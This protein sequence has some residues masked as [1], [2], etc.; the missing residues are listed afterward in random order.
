[1]VLARRFAALSGSFDPE[2][3]RDV[4][5]DASPEVTLAVTADLADACDTG[6]EGGQ[7]L[8]RGSVRR[9]EIDGL[10]TAGELDQ[11]ISWRKTLPL[12]DA[13]EDLLA[14]LAGSGRYAETAVRKTIDEYA[15]RDTLNRIAVAL[16][17]AGERAPAHG[18]MEAARSALGRLDARDRAEVMLNRGFFGRVSETQQIAAWL[19]RPTTKRPVTALFVTGLPGIGK[20]TLVDEAARRASEASPPWIIVR[21]DF[22]RSALDVQDLV[23]LTMEIARQVSIAVGDE[24]ERLRRALIAAAGAAPSA[25]PDVKGERRE[26]VPDELAFTLGAV[27]RGAGRQTLLILDTLEVLRGRGETHPGQLSACLDELCDRGLTPLAVV[28]AGRGD[29]LDSAADRIGS[30]IDLP[31]LDPADAD[32]MLGGLD[33]PQTA[34]ADIRELAEGNPLVLRLAA[35]AVRDAGPEALTRARGRKEVAAAYLYRFLLSRITDPTLRRLAQPGLVVRR[36]NPDVIAEVLAPQLKLGRL[37]PT[38]AVALFD[39]LAKHHWL[40]EP[41]PTPGWVRHRSD[42]RTVLLRLLYSGSSRATAARIDR[43]AA[44][45][46]ERRPESFAQVEAAYHRLQA[47]RG[48]ADPPT[49]DPQVIHLFDKETIAELPQAA[50]DRVRTARGERT[51]RLR[52]TPKRRHHPRWSWPQPMSWR[53]CSSRPSSSR[54]PSSTT[55][56]SRSRTSIRSPPK[57]GI[58]QTL[59][60][61]AGRWRDATKD[62]RQQRTLEPLDDASFNDRSPLSALADLEMWAEMQFARLIRILERDTS[63]TTY[64][65]DLL[66]R[67]IKGGLGSGALGFALLHAG[68]PRGSASRS[69]FNPVEG[70]VSVWTGDPTFAVDALARPASQLATRVSPS[71]GL[72]QGG[73]PPLQPRLPDASTPAGAARFLAASSPYASVAESLRSLDR[74]R[75][76]T[77]LASVDFDIAEA[78]GLPPSGAGD[79]SVSAAVSPDGSIESVASLGLLAE[80]LGAAAFVLR[81]PDLHLLAQSAERWRRANG[82]VWGYPLVSRT[83]EPPWLRRPDATTADR[84]QQLL[85][86]DHPVA[87]AEDQL[88]LWWGGSTGD[89]PSLAERI[90]RRFPAAIREARALQTARNPLVRRSGPR[91]LWSNGACHLPSFRPWRCSSRRI[92]S[93]GG[94]RHDRWFGGRPA[95]S[96]EVTWS[97]CGGPAG[98]R[99]RA[100]RTDGGIEHA[101]RGGWYRRARGDD[102][103]RGARSNCAAGG[104]ASAADQER[105]GGARHRC[106]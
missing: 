28:A 31:G 100:A 7:W 16:D 94:D 49:I 53:R 11:A 52:V 91:S 75:V 83:D 27:I 56:R 22:D 105:C 54:P 21:L 50:Q 78:G 30:R 68:A 92:E 62:L 85:Q 43:A 12:D 99:Q 80:W 38:R 65:A 37:E 84:I 60:S 18:A 67:G 5:G 48:G 42:I 3:L 34:F 26:H 20:S 96:G 79:W 35:M 77:H 82:G 17:R 93:K 81:H 36:I 45:W 8:M 102:D 104:S 61:R 76:G 14:A 39:A 106:R 2:S 6:A 19:A 66:R 47:M 1:M 86:A 46:F 51:S 95:A 24:A 29:A 10:A 87:S 74:G 9:R 41:D 23:G 33:V 70:A 90:G 40:V 88:R 71:A 72:V 103:T 15:G 13:A 44:K 57:D 97:R 101:V 64:A 25:D 63:L 73:R 69:L 98:D 58:A 89:A 4:I 55:V 32:A 59:L